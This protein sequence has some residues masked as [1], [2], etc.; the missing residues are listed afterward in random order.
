[1]GGASEGVKKC[2][3]SLLSS[4]GDPWPIP[5]F[6]ALHKIFLLWNKTVM[7]TKKLEYYTV[8]IIL[9]INLHRTRHSYTASILKISVESYMKTLLKSLIIRLHNRILA[10]ELNIQTVTDLYNYSSFTYCTQ[11]LN[12]SNSCMHRCSEFCDMDKCMKPVG[13]I[14]KPSLTSLC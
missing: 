12:S 11:V 10:L 13:Y 14:T 1:M 9:N 5:H 3:M 2:L 4:N 7:F 8:A 6:N